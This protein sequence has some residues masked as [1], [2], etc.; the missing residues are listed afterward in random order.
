MVIEN[1]FAE[2]EQIVHGILSGNSA[3]VDKGFK[4]DK[5]DIERVVHIE[6]AAASCPNYVDLTP[7]QA[8]ACVGD[9]SNVRRLI[10]LQANLE[11]GGSRG[12]TP[13]MFALANKHEDVA[14]VLLDAGTRANG[15]SATGKTPLII[16]AVFGERK[17]AEKLLRS[18]ADVKQTD[19]DGRTALLMATDPV[20]ARMLVAFGSDTNI[21]DHKGVTGLHIAAYSGNVAMIDFWLEAG[22]SVDARDHT[23]LTPLDAARKGEAVAARAQAF[24]SGRSSARFNLPSAPPATPKRNSEAVERLTTE[25][26][27]L[28]IKNIDAAVAAGKEGDSAKA[29]QLWSSAVRRASDIGPGPEDNAIA[30]MLAYI[31]TLPAW[32]GLPEEAREHVIRAQYFLDRAKNADGATR[33]L[34]LAL[35]IAPWWADGYHDLGII[36]EGS[37]N[38]DEAKRRLKTFLAI[39]PDDSKARA[40]R[41]K[42]V[43]IDIAKEQEDKVASMAGAWTDGARSWTVSVRGDSMTISGNSRAFTMS[44][45]EGLLEGT[46]NGD[47]GVV[48]SCSYPGQKHPATGKYD[49]EARTIALDS[50]W[51]TYEVHWHCVNAFGNPS[52][53]CLFCTKQ[54]DGATLQKDEDWHASLHPAQK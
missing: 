18:G 2:H 52:N 49:A 7:L 20:I 21:V 3:M 10:G 29:L 34:H 54:C 22:A 51:S 4:S 26:N 9:E 5:K 27:N 50:M 8:A 48:S 43:E 53:C 19:D 33:E 14:L 35:A 41:D 28:L 38:H 40:V 17:A 16:A 42:I 37:G 6:K 1:S 12:S 46:M 32:P 39:A 47:G 25:M 45:H 31:A 23:G 13:L 11:N 36:E 30:S 24:G 44:M 15:K